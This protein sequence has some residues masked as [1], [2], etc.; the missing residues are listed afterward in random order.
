MVE[1]TLETTG[2]GTA[3]VHTSIGYGPEPNW[4]RH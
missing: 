2:N 3:T 4:W 1:M